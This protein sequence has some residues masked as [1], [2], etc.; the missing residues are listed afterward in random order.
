MPSPTPKGK[1]FRPAGQALHNLLERRAGAEIHGGPPL[2]GGGKM[3]MSIDDAWNHPSPRRVHLFRRSGERVPC[4]LVILSH[5]N[6]PFPPGQK[7]FALTR[8]R[9]GRDDSPFRSQSAREE[10]CP[11]LRRE[12][13]QFF[14]NGMTRRLPFLHEKH[15]ASTKPPTC[16]FHCSPPWFSPEKH[17]LTQLRWPRGSLKATFPAPSTLRPDVPSSAVVPRHQHTAKRVLLR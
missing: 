7:G 17:D 16:A 14:R 9:S 3:H 4:H 11:F 12:P 8:T 13:S 10:A 2:H 5:G 6:N 15:P 1:R